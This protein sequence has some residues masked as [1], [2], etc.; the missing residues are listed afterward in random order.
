MQT[1][2]SSPGSKRPSTISV[3]RSSV[4]EHGFFRGLYTG[5]TASL[6]RQMSYSLV[7]LGSYEAIKQKISAGKNPSTAH[8]LLAAAVSGGFGGVAGNPA[9]VC[10]R[11]MPS[12]LLN[13]FCRHHPC[14]NDK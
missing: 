13:K 6:M 5:L 9:G 11:E 14:E 1:L 8:L 4:A 10:S 3:L 2:Q 7:R 12:S